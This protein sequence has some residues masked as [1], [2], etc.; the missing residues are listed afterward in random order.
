MINLLE[1]EPVHIAGVLVKAFPQNTQIIAQKLNVFPG[2]EVHEI[3]DDGSMVVTVE[4]T[5]KEKNVVDIITKL[6]V[7]EGVLDASLIFH[8]NDAGLVP[9]AK[10]NDGNVNFK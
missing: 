7:I 6:S 2:T 10:N 5:D 1:Q 4:A 9:H 8:H 3:S